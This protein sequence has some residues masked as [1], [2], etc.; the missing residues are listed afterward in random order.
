MGQIAILNDKGHTAVKWDV[1]EPETVDKARMTYQQF[2]DQG[3]LTFAVATP[4]ATAEQIREFDPSADS[5]VAV[6]RFVGG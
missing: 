2:L 5:I 3:F 6:K 4:G 1:A